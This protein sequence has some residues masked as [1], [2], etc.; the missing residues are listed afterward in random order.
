M[1]PHCDFVVL[2]KMNLVLAFVFTSGR[3]LGQKYF[4]KYGIVSIACEV[5]R[6]KWPWNAPVACVSTRLR[7]RAHLPPFLV[8]EKLDFYTQDYHFIM[9]STLCIFILLYAA[10]A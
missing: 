10:F 4:T 6:E 7:L 2:S 9:K 1:K 5:L 3:Q 8:S